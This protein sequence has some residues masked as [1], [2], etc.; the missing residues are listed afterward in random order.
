MTEYAGRVLVIDD[1]QGTCNLCAQTLGAAGF[2][3]L[4][5][6]A[7]PSALA[8]LNAEMCDLVL[9]SVDGPQQMG[10]THLSQIRVVDAA[11]PVLL[12]SRSITVPE[13]A[14]MMRMGVEGLLVKPFDPIELR[15]VAL[16]IITKQRDARA[17][18]RV[19]ALRPLLQVA[20]R[21]LAELDLSRLQDLIIETV[22]SELR[23]D[24]ASLMLLEEDGTHL[25]IVACSGL[26]PGITVGHRV[27][28]NQG[29]A[30]WVAQNRMCL[31]IDASGEVFPPHADVRGVFLE[32]QMTSSLAVPV[33][34][35]DQVL[36]VLNASKVLSGTSFS[37]ADQDLLLLLA[38]QAA[39]AITNARLYTQ[40]AHSEARYRTLLH[41]ANDAVLLLDAQAR[42]IL[43]ANLALEQLSG[44][45]RDELLHL[46]PP[47]LLPEV[48]SLLRVGRN[49]ATNGH[50][51]GETQEI[52]TILQTRDAQPTRV[53][54]S[55]SVVPYAGQQLL[56]VMARDISER[57]RITNQ[58]LQTEKLAAL[59]R[60]SASMAHEINNPLQAINN[61]VH[62]LLN[63][64]LTDEKRQRYLEMTREEIDHL[65]SIVQ[66]I[67]DFHRPSREGMRP[68]DL[69]EILDGVLSLT[70]TQLHTQQIELIREIDPDLPHVLA[71]GSHMRQVCLS[72][73]FN[74][75]EAMNAGGELRVRAY[76][77]T[78][79]EDP[80]TDLFTIAVERRITPPMCGPMVVVEISDTGPGIP[81][82]D[83]HKIFEPFYTT[84]I[85][86]TG[87]SLAMTYNII[88]QHHGEMAVRSIPGQGATFRIRLPV[89]G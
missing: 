51:P 28:T 18:E 54:V 75:I 33:L 72:L 27:A 80:H 76:L 85:K 71:V 35:G 1:D 36:G 48:G 62:L 63:R 29:L 58:L 45:T 65:I 17:R 16:E 42:S 34:A 11:I 49:G 24:R 40:V 70:S 47:D 37:A 82:Q 20:G 4:T 10:M 86:G 74:A 59:G 56:L 39:T 8:Y 15:D 61:A 89:A 60:L 14:R 78:E 5:T 67:L 13:I 6:P 84:R 88:E 32:D 23:A 64:S 57:Q 79:Q 25:R 46:R 55:V 50:G 9:L 87:L 77:V 81:T 19:A 66:R 41:H 31:C 69:V 83:L 26:P 44:Y 12:L 53:A 21:L 2:A 7:S 73:I 22:R 43:E 52:E 30:G 3:V 68:V 38:G